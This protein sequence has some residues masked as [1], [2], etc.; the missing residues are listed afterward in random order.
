MAEAMTCKVD[1]VRE[2][3]KAENK[4]FDWEPK[5]PVKLTKL[6]EQKISSVETNKDLLLDDEEYF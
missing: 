2:W 6:G 4:L 1:K 3:L 5:Q